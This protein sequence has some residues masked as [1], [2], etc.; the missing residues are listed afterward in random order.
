MVLVAGP[1]PIDIFVKQ[2]ITALGFSD[3]DISERVP[4][5]CSCLTC[6]RVG[7]SADPDGEQS[8]APLKTACKLIAHPTVLPGMGAN[9]HACHYRLINRLAD[10]PLD[11]FLPERLGLL[12]Y[13]AVQ[14]IQSHVRMANLPLLINRIKPMLVL[15]MRKG[16]ER[17][18]AQRHLADS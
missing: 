2:I 4:S 10:G 17:F 9:Q 5:R 15:W 13:R 12:R 3:A 11:L 1:L 16:E 7:N 6:L 14:A 8:V 18:R